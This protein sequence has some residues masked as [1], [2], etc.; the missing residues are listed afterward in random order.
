MEEALISLEELKPYNFHLP[1]DLAIRH[2]MKIND[3]FGET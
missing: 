1:E 2:L 3:A